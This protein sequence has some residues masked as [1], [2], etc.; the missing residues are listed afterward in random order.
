MAESLTNDPV[1][2]P[3]PE[4]K[5]KAEREGVDIMDYVNSMHA[6][7]LNQRDEIKRL[8]ERL[9]GMGAVYA[10][11]GIGS[12]ARTPNVLLVNIQNARRRSECLSAIE[13][14]FFTRTTEDD[15]GEEM[16]DCPLSWGVEPEEYV[17]QF[18]EA[19]T[20]LEHADDK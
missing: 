14:E 6:H 12:K 1:I 11:F 18:R 17:K 15:E 3:W 13:H 4:M 16:E 10:A 20:A 5:K 7:I 8:N 9:A 2:L 19:L